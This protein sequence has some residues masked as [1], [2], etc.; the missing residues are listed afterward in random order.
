MDF[1]IENIL[2]HDDID[3]LKEFLLKKKVVVDVAEKVGLHNFHNGVSIPA[4]KFI[5]DGKAIY[6]F[7]YPEKASDKDEYPKLNLT[8][9]FEQKYTW[10]NL[11]LNKK[12]KEI[13]IVRDKVSWKNKGN[14]WDVTVDIGLVF[15]FDFEQLF[16]KAI[17][18]IGG[19]MEYY[20]DAKVLVENKKNILEEY[21]SFKSDSFLS[22]D[23]NLI[24][25][26]P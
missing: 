25:I 21:W 24:K 14:F 10:F 12:I 6:L 5:I 19:L 8:K 17:D 11:V 22:L 20:F 2:T 15:S 4:L 18:S 3:K 7:N 9:N 26:A 16:I 13:Y 23:R 1:V